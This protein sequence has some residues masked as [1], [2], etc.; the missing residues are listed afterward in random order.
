MIIRSFDNKIVEINKSNYSCDTDYYSD[1]VYYL[2]GVHFVHNSNTPEEI[3]NYLTK[4]ML[5]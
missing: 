1:L 4:K 2:Y 5:V 3:K